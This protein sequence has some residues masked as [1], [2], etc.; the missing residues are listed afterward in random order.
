MY[1][2]WQRELPATVEVVPIHLPGRDGRLREPCFRRLDPLLDALQQA[3]TPHL[4]LPYAFYG[5]SMGGWVAYY[6]TQR[7]AWSGDRLPS[8]LFL[9]A[10]R[11]PHLTF[12]QPP[13]HALPRD[14]FIE[15]V[16]LRYGQ[17]PAALLA[18]SDLMDLL[19][20]IIQAD[21]ELFETVEYRPADP[22]PIPIS[23]FAGADDSG[24]SVADVA[25]WKE[26]TQ[27]RFS[28]E[29]L[30]GDHFFLKTSSAA[31]LSRL[32]QEMRCIPHAA[33]V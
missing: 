4:D 17:F 7:F 2:G 29:T 28:F 16:S 9:G 25:A 14:R 31:L 15:Q 11:A 26:H 5:H 6:L 27:S 33:S 10:S 32:G 20:P 18:H 21:M 13:I 12:R 22:L 19:V 24:V 23:A 30:P 3:L 1:A 8:H